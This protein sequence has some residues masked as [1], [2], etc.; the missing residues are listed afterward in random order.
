[1]VEENWRNKAIESETNPTETKQNY[2]EENAPSS[3]LADTNTFSSNN[4]NEIQKNN[5]D[6][7]IKS[8]I[9]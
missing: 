8:K 3:T 1:M 5:T 2:A 6:N 4:T 9:F 7:E